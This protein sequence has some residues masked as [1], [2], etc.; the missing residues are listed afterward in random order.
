MSVTSGFFNSINHDRVYDATHFSDI[1]DGV[2]N[3]GVFA[4]IGDVFAVKENTADIVSVG[5]GK[6][7]FNKKWIDNDAILPLS[8]P[9]AEILLDRYDAVV[10]EVDES[11]AVRDCFIKFI[12][13]TPASNPQYPPLA[14]TDT[15]HQ[16][17]LAFIRRKAGATKITQADI[18]N[19]VGTSYCPYI[20]GILEVHNIDHIVAQWEAQWKQWMA[21]WDGWEG[22]WEEWYSNITSDA[23][24]EVYTFINSMG[25]DFE[26]WYKELQVILEPDVA[27]NLAARVSE[28]Q[29][30]FRLLAEEGCV[31]EP[32]ED[33]DG[34]ALIDEHGGTI[35]GTTSL[36]EIYERPSSGE[37][38]VTPTYEMHASKH[39][40]DGMDPIDPA[41]IGAVPIIGGTMTGA[42][43]A[44][45][46]TSTT[47]QVRNV[48]SG[49][50]DMT[51]NSTSLASGVIYLMYE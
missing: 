16:Y 3:D 35:L 15:L 40:A 43:I 2:I 12:K 17:P 14:K 20:T 29:E 32:L 25:A 42:L 49:T 21:Q 27:T 46:N 13:G 7:W 8:M 1:F 30:R 19:C 45:N 36:V 24:N 11:V 6:A 22:D 37:V 33:S 23:D 28:L 5:I 51:P 18:I 9:Q 41:S 10:I 26:R 50:S 44:Q 31:Y 48:Y 47:P 34:V 38:V 4:N 39:A